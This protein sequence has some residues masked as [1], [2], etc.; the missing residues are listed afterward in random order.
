MAE[1]ELAPFGDPTEMFRNLNT[2]EDYL[3]LRG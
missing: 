1:D 2:P 3:R